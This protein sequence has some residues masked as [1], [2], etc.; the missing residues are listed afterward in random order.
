MNDQEFNLMAKHFRKF[1]RRNGKLQHG[2][3]HN[4]KSKVGEESKHE[5]GCFNCG[6]KNHFISN[7]PK[8]KNHK[9][10]VGGVW[11]DD[12]DG[13]YEDKE[14]RCLMAIESNEVQS[15]SNIFNSSLDLNELEKENEELI[16]NYEEVTNYNN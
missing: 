5:Y 8:P 13:E 15:N 12:E 14:A 2:G 1:F 10:F 7:C 6:E 3:H 9:A 16:N 11:S 4:K